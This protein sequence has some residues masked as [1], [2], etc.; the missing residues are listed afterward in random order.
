MAKKTAAR[1]KAANKAAKA[2]TDA[3]AKFSDEKYQDVRFSATFDYDEMCFVRAAEQL[4]PRAKT[5]MTAAN[6][7][8]LILLVLVALFAGDQT[9]LLIILFF[10]AVALIYGARNWQG[11]QQRYARGTMLAPDPEAARTHVAVCEDAIHVEN[12]KGPVL[13][14]SYSDLRFVHSTAESLVAVFTGRRYVFVPRS[15][16]SES[17]FHELVKFLRGKL[18]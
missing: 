2:K 14:C 3:S 17:R 13:D 15:A 16:L 6:F 1:R 12:A 11:L 18:R 4:G 10:V 8:S 9:V 7:G 5:A